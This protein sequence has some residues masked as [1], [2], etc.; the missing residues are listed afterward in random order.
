M[1]GMAW[2]R[3][4]AKYILNAHRLEQAVGCLDAGFRLCVV[5]QL[6]QAQPSIAVPHRR[7][8]GLARG[9]CYLLRC[10]LLIDVFTANSNI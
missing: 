10:C 8:N 5:Q 9:R 6:Q 3:M 2:N 4:V 1:L 7:A